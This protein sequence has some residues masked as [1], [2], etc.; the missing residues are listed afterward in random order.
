LCII[1]SKDGRVLE[2]VKLRTSRA[3]FE[4]FFSTAT[5]MRVALE[6]GTHSP[7]ASRVVSA[8]GHEVIVANARQ[9]RLVHASKRKSDRLDAEKLARLMRFDEQLL[10]PVQHRG[11]QAQADLSVLRSRASLVRGRTQQINTVRGLVKSFGGRLPKGASTAFHRAAGKH[12]PKEL[13]PALLP[14]LAVIEQL[15][16]QIMALEMRIKELAHRNYPEAQLL[17]QVKGV[18]EITSL[19]FILSLEDPSRFAKSRSV[20]A[21]LGLAP[22]QRQSGARDLSMHISKEGDEELRRLLVQ[23]AHR[24]LGRYSQDSD[25]KRHGESII[26]QGGANAKRR[27]VIAVARKLAVLLHHLWATG[28]VYE[29][30]KNSRRVEKRASQT[31]PAT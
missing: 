17:M 18:A 5:G 2:E 24:I 6:T 29:P 11:R 19:T 9:V 13:L 21:Y 16:V 10:A 25:L 20:G 3:A 23:C 22:G 30:L 28:E 4:R 27:A 14:N 7:W 1:D 26:Q 12:M 15:N 31:T 8:C